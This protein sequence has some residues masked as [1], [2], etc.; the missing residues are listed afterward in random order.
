MKEIIIIIILLL[1]LVLTVQYKNYKRNNINFFTRKKN[2][3]VNLIGKS[4]GQQ[5]RNN[6]YEYYS[7]KKVRFADQPTYYDCP[8]QEQMNEQDR[9][10]DEYVYNSRVFCK[11][12]PAPTSET[13][14]AEYRRD[15]F[16]FREKTNQIANNYSPVDR[17]DEMIV[18]NPNLQGMKISEVYDALTSNEF[19]TSYDSINMPEQDNAGINYINSNNNNSSFM[20]Y[21]SNIY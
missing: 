15:I 8:R 16:D 12:K 14:L 20:G 3:N 1:V 18:N 9:F 17:M 19:N 10:I 11:N 4:K 21:K 2:S 5:M 13:P 7:K 6:K